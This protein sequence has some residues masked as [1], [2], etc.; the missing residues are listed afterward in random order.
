MKKDTLSLYIST[1]CLI[2]YFPKCPGTVASL[3]GLL[4]VMLTSTKTALYF[5][6]LILFLIMGFFMSG[7]VERMSNKKDPPEVVIDEFCGMLIS[8]FFIK[9]T[10]FNLVSSFVFF[11]IF[12]ILKPF[13]INKI[14][15]LKGSAGIMLD[16]ILSGIF[17]NL[18][19]RVIKIAYF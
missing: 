12:D 7:R 19:L 4:V 17:V 5:I 9:P 13:P 1:L 6:V 11:R 15:N 2:G 8:V 3:F 14:G 10:I 16:D 18:I